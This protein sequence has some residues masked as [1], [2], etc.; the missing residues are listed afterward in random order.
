MT[1]LASI[2]IGTYTAR[3]MVALVSDSSSKLRPIE[4]RRT[5]IFT[6]EGFDSSTRKIIK[7]EAFERVLA[8]LEDFLA[9]AGRHGA[10]RVIGVATG[11]VREAGNGEE[12][13]R[14]LEKN[15][16]VALK[17]ITGSEE[18]VLTAKGVFSSMGL[19]GSENI[20]FD[21]G[22]G[23]TEF[24]LEST[25]GA[26]IKSVPFGAFTLTQRFLKSDPPEREYVEALS[27]HV[28]HCLELS[29]Q[30]LDLGS[31]KKDLIG[32]GGSVV[33]LGAL[34]HGIPLEAMNPDKMNGLKLR[35]EELDNVLCDI[36]GLNVDGRIKVTGLDRG[37]AE[38]I[39]A[40]ILSTSRIM[41][42]FDARDLTVSMSDILE[43][44]LIDE[45]EGDK[46]N[47]R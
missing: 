45:V 37:R 47:G 10:Q 38:V 40:G 6:G 16:G 34:I 36:R 1:V 15:S 12:F 21:L 2:D 13:I 14:Y 3:L 8:A 17:I 30:G 29:F 4:R 22:G 44:L 19:K 24:I 25:P 42:Y 41:K 39:L 26:I 9:A 5:Y 35:Y 31:E 20:L 11:A 23:S 28:D 32:T 46:K 7:R 27:D 18:A 33:S 43:G